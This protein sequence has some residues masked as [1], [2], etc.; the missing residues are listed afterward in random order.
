MQIHID[1]K[2]LRKD[3]D[4]VTRVFLCLWTVDQ[5]NASFHGRPV[6]LH[7]RDFGRDVTACIHSQDNCFRLLLMT[8]ELLG[9]VISLY[10]PSLA[11][12]AESSLAS[13]ASFEDLVIAAGAMRVPSTLL[14]T[15]ETLYHSVAILSYRFDALTE[16]DRSAPAYVRQSLSTS[17]IISIVGSE[18]E[19]ELSMVPFVPYAVS[20]CLRVA[21][22]ELRVSKAPLERTRSRRQLLKT[23]AL[24]RQFGDAFAS[25]STVAGL[26]EQTVRELDK[27]A[28]SMIEQG[29]CNDF[30]STSRR[31]SV[32]HRLHEQTHAPEQANNVGVAVNHTVDPPQYQ[33]TDFVPPVDFDLNFAEL[34]DPDADMF[35][36][37]NPDFNLEA[38]DAVLA[39]NVYASGFGF[40]DFDFG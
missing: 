3:D 31:G 14:A 22:R 5:L 8:I 13:L 39:P 7:E 21:Y 20:L 12:A 33:A 37:F 4:T 40:P 26:A 16:P 25:A 32:F 11:S 30:N 36:H 19:N 38:I 6:M 28:A 27:V 35:Q 17:R 10:R 34:P 15:I 1:T 18:F 29:P 2:G 23:C 24:L 9:R